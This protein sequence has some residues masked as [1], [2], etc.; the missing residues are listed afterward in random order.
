M[1]EKAHDSNHH[2]SLKLGFKF[3]AN[4]PILMT[5][6]DKGIPGAH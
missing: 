4:S 3:L 5:T 6:N 2:L 1:K